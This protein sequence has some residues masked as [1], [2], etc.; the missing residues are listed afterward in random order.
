MSSL[1][2]DYLEQQE[3]NRQE[4]AHQ[5]AQEEAHKHHVIQE[6]SR[7]V[8]SE[9]PASVLGQMDEEAKDELK[10]TLKGEW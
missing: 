8:L 10:L 4:E 5:Q 2:N 3:E 7:L 1:H 6:F 9:G